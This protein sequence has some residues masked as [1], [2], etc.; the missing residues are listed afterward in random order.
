MCLLMF[1][2]SVLAVFIN[3]LRKYQSILYFYLLLNYYF[4][5]QL[6]IDYILLIWTYPT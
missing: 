1:N 4:L 5:M 6:L 2:I 3:N